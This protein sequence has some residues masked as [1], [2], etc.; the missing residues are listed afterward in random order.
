VQGKYFVLNSFQELF[1]A[2]NEYES[3]LLNQKNYELAD[4]RE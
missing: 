4:I 3:I 2:L 1:D